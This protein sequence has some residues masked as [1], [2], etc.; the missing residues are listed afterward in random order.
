MASSAALSESMQRITTSKLN[1]LKGQRSAYEE[2]KRTVLNAVQLERDLSTQVTGLLDALIVFDVPVIDTNLSPKNIRRFLNQR[3]NDPSVSTSMLEE[4]KSGL[5]RCFDIQSHKYEYASLFGQLV[6]EW[7]EQPSNAP[8]LHRKS[9]SESTSDRSEESFE[10]VGR[11]EMYDQWREWETLVFDRTKK[12]DSETIKAYLSALFNSTAK[13]KKLT[14]TPLEDLRA[15][16]KAFDLGK[17]DKDSLKWCIKGLFKTD[18]LV[19]SK[20]AALL[21][22]K[23]NSLV[24]GEM[25]DVL[26]IQIDNIDQWSWGDEPIPIELRRQVNGKYRFYMDEELLQALLI[27]FVGIKWSVHIKEAF[28]KFFHSGAWKQSS[29][30]ALDRK[31]RAR[32][33]DFLGNAA[34]NQNTIRNQRRK[35]FEQNYFMTQLPSSIGEGARDYG[36]G[37]DYDSDSD[38]GTDKKSPVE[39]KQSLLHLV[40]TESLINT[41]LYGSFT[42][43]QSDFRWFGPSLP[44]STVYAV[45]EFLGVKDRWLKFF[46]KFL[47]TPLKFVQDGPQAPTNVRRCGIPIDHALSDALGESVLFCLDFAVNQAT[48]T[49]LYRFHDDLWFWGQEDVCVKAWE[50]IGEFSR[51]MG[52]SVNEEKTGAVQVTQGSSTPKVSK[53]LPKGKVQW[54][55][56]NLDPSGTWIINNEQVD[57]H[58]EELR[59]QLKACKSVMATV[60]A[61]NVY[62]SKFLANNFGRPQNCLGQRHIDMVITT[63]DQIQQ[64]LFLDAFGSSSLVD[65]LKKIVGERF[66]V[67]DLPDGFFYFPVELGG[68]GVRNPL[69]PLLLVREVEG[70]EAEKQRAI[71]EIKKQKDPKEWIEEALELEEAEYEKLKKRYDAGDISPR[72]D[73]RVRKTKGDDESFMS[74]E[75]FTNYREETSA[76]LHNA[77]EQLQTSP[78][79]RDVTS[80]S[81]VR[82]A[83][84]DLPAD[85]ADTSSGIHDDWRSMEPYY[86]WVAQLYGGDVLKRF[87]SLSMGEKKLLPTGLVKMLRDEK[88]RWQG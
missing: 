1:V 32:R 78:N 38:A 5:L 35:D 27:Y 9:S 8:A 53:S 86:K 11:Q 50:T 87:G 42:V 22:I 52:L 43:L 45:I 26:N 56:L 36:D 84:D 72:S 80:T 69:I 29:Y 85:L 73:S 34:R 58:I 60:Q 79:I 7:L 21:D 10:A 20:R 13:S 23:D 15:R 63:F 16:M 77:Y 61:W 33:E 70:S 49:N 57:Q 41:S 46:R 76:Y 66:N 48:Q 83:I 14:K 19:P 82:V 24:L 59:R 65:Y 68:L 55:F 54:G 28:T 31:A 25:V 30:R 4:W 51:V 6:T 44:H 18:L 37:T 67:K 47:K 74:I 88:V 62:V 64:R 12:S 81:D 39:I 3:R 71:G 2:K 17:F 75:E 40:T